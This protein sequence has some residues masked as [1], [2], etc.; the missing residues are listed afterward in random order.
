MDIERPTGLVRY[1]LPIAAAHGFIAVALGAF[2][3][4][5][6]KTRLSPEALV[7]FDT[8]ARYQLAHA[9]ALAIVAIAPVSGRAARVSAACFAVGPLI[10]SGSL[11]LLALTGERRL[12]AITPVGGG[13]QLVGWLALGWS[14][15]A[16]KL[17][18][19][20]SG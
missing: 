11:Y 10:F 12:G 3:A 17:Q 14:A 1:Y 15:L 16:H 4:H 5:L 6:L 2:A 8:A 9:L 18:R 13:L 7:Q 19:R 20:R